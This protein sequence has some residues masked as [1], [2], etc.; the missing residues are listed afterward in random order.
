MLWIARCNTGSLGVA[1]EALQEAFISFLRRFDPGSGAPPLAW[2]TTTLK[3][4]CW[5][6][7]RAEKLDRRVSADAGRE[8]GESGTLLESIPTPERTLEERVADRDEARRQLAGLKPDERTGLGLLAA[9]FSYKEI[10]RRRDWS[11]TKVNRCVS[12]GRA[13]LATA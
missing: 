10:A 7:Q 13:A 1:E 2:L 4:E 8:G 5:A 11:Y 6:R 3:R 12:E 9:G